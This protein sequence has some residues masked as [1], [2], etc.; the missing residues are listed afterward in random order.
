MVLLMFLFFQKL[1]ISRIS[2]IS[3]TII[4]DSK[5]LIMFKTSL[6]L[7]SYL[8]PSQVHG[9]SQVYRSEHSLALRFQHQYQNMLTHGALSL[10]ASSRWVPL[11]LW[12]PLPVFS[13][14]FGNSLTLVY[15]T[16]RHIVQNKSKIVKCF[17]RLKCFSMLKDCLD[18]E[19]FEFRTISNFPQNVP[20]Q[21]NPAS[22][23]YTPPL[24]HLSLWMVLFDMFD[25][26]GIISQVSQNGCLS[27][28]CFCAV[29]RPD[30]SASKIPRMFSCRKSFLISAFQA[31]SA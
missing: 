22:D 14:F 12:R 26:F 31:F 23:S 8:N 27:F 10:R 1:Q 2:K 5:F 6:H 16:F 28:D 24:L 7:Y 13:S 11:S 25:H 15:I 21:M 20:S 3:K 9:R 4:F 19:V 17:K 18:F 30:V 29:V